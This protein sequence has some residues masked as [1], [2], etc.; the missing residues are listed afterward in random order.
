[1]Y[2]VGEDIELFIILQL[3]SALCISSEFLFDGSEV[4]PSC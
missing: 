3:D 2:A 4:L 1:M